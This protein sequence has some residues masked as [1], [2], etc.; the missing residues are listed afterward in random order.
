MH[1]LQSLWGLF[2]NK[3]LI[4]FYPFKVSNAK[5][6]NVNLQLKRCLGELTVR[7]NL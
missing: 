2:M 7:P 6:A 1:I 5:F 4:N 3:Q